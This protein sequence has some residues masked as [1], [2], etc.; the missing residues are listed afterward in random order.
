MVIMNYDEIPVVRTPGSSSDSGD[1]PTMEMDTSDPYA[2]E[3]K[4]QNVDK[5]EALLVVLQDLAGQKEMD[6]SVS[7]SDSE[8]EPNLHMDTSDPFASQKEMDTVAKFRNVDLDEALAVVQNVAGQTNDE[9]LVSVLQGILSDNP[10]VNRDSAAT[11]YFIGNDMVGMEMFEMADEGG[12]SGAS[13]S[14]SGD[15]YYYSKEDSDDN[16][17]ELPVTDPDEEMPM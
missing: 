11:N 2:T 16:H 3:V 14:D 12:A 9:K 15:Y 8:D 4:S 7:F 1:V 10:A 6:T 5:D 13:E 17:D